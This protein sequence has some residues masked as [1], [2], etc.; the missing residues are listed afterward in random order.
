MA[1]QKIIFQLV[2]EDSGL[3]S[4][5]EQTRATIRSLNK[6]IRANPGPERF[7]ELTAELAASR[8][9]LADL[10]G[11]QKKLTKEFQ[12]LKVP[13]DSLAGLR[14]EY[15]KLSQAVAQLSAEERKSSFGKELIKNAAGVKKEIDGIEQSMGRFT[16]NVG[17][18]RSALNGLGSVFAALG[19]GAGIGEIINANTRVSDAIADVAKTAGIATNEAQQLADVL[20]FRDT[21][22]SLVDQLKIAQIGG[23]LGVAKEQ[24]LG[25]TESVDVLNV[26]LGDQFGN[27]E[28][29]TRVIAGLRNVLTDFKTGDVSN[30]VLRLGNALNFLEAQGNATAPTIA[31]F[32]NR[33][34]GSA[35]PLGVT[36]QEIFG[37][38]TA[39]AELNINPERGATAITR[40]LIEVAR[41]P[42]VFAKSLGFTKQQTED[43]AQ[44]VNTD[45]VGAVALVSKTIAEGGDGVKNFAQTLDEIGIDRAG[46]IEVLGKLGGNTA[47]LTQRIT[48]STDALQATD[49]VYAEFDKKNN[50]AAAAVE[51]LQNAVVNLIT[52]E[53]AQDAIES[54]AKA[55][56]NLVNV[57]GDTLAAV[58]D[59]K[60]EF[61]LLA[62]A[63]FAFTGPGQAAS[64][65]IVQITTALKASTVAGT[66]NVGVTN[67]QTAATRALA[68][69]QAALPLLA[70]VAGI[71]AVVKAFEFYNENLSA[72]EKAS[73]AVADA[74]KEIAES[75]AKEIVALRESIGVLQQSTST[76]EERA[77]AIKSLTDKYP[78]YLKGIDL[79][80]QGTEALTV[81][82]RELTDAI[83]RSAAERAKAS[84]KEKL[85][86][87][88]V[89]KRLKIEETRTRKIVSRVEGEF[90]IDQDR[91]G[92]AQTDISRRADEV[93]ALEDE[94]KDLE[95]QI[96]ALD[97][98]FDKVFKLDQPIESAIPRTIDGKAVEK[99]KASIKSA[100][101]ELTKEEKKAADKAKSEREK[102]ASEESKR[103]EEQQKRIL[104]IQRTVR[105]LNL[106]EESEFQRK[107]EELDNRRTDSLLQNRQRIDTLR[108]T[109]EERTGTKI[110]GDVSTGAELAAKIPNARP[111]DITEANLIDAE[112]DA[113]KASFDKQ[114]TELFAQRKATQEAQAAQLRQLLAD[115]AKVAADNEATAAVSVQQDIQES[116][117]QRRTFLE[118]EFS[119]REEANKVAFSRGEITR[120]EFE[121]RE[122]SDSIE[123]T[124]RKLQLETEYA[125]RVSE[126]VNQVRDV[127][128]AAAQAELDAQLLTIEQQRKQ[129]VAGAEKTAKDTGTDASAQISAI[130]EKAANDAEAAQ[131]R[132]ADAVKAS[133]DDAK[134]VQLQ[135]VD[136]VDAARQA[137]HDAELARI[138]SEKQKRAE[139]RDAA[140]QTAGEI[141]SG[142]LAIQRNND[143][144]DKEAKLSAI[145]EEYEKKKKAAQGNAQV[146]EK[147]EKEQAKKKEAVEKE[148]AEKRKQIAI[149]EAV[150]NTAQA[151]VKAAPNPLLMAFAAAVGAVQ[152]G[153]ISSQKFAEGGF[154]DEESAA[155]GPSSNRAGKKSK[156][157]IYPKKMY[158]A[159][160]DLSRGGYTGQG[161]AQRDDTGHR[162]AG[163]IPGSNAVVHAGEYVAPAWQVQAMPELFGDL[164]SQR[165]KKT[166]PFAQ[167]GFTHTKINFGNFAHVRQ[168]ATG[169]FADP[170]LA[171][172]NASEF[173]QQM[174]S[175]S[176]S[177]S[178]TDAQIQEIGRIIAAEN[179]RVVQRSIAEG[180]GDANRRLEREKSLEEQR[181]I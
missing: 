118:K 40:L 21:R 82:Y 4:R 172:P 144:A 148:A 25:F 108:K 30:D 99:S 130:N 43:F 16:G 121:Q 111:A 134:A 170:V 3:T 168:Y 135:A 143:E 136:A 153:V 72:A 62:S 52:S 35:I 139:I 127:R 79:E 71:Y 75:S 119:L 55:A 164:E 78:E 63:L 179:G 106:T 33:I 102:R 5:I 37:L 173:R 114:R 88:I 2:V 120:K 24:L 69:A 166:K 180:L 131:L 85:A 117:E 171:M 93:K 66:L 109:V 124:N 177:A 80:K 54:V 175:V 94:A 9:V 116:F 12:A 142:L 14:L 84:A 7:A 46:A 100:G 13:K 83:I 101:A 86:T 11:E 133:T 8:R 105:D 151:I 74:Q 27:V 68:A 70:V 20:E 47:L 161:T 129:G 22:T 31:E 115:T 163:K 145:D 149:I 92:A 155:P 122:L 67:L 160:P 18:Y 176:A 48:E 141:A 34:S 95:K 42:E 137:T 87:E 26:S 44:Q 77:K 17:N 158:D 104:E 169:G 138:E 110:T 157:G 89:E 60:A 15:G 156:T 154:T 1:T 159:L 51:K 165:R 38:S 178:F 96:E 23:Q 49:S 90:S 125:T 140:V 64:A 57:L 39:L 50:N 61:A 146:I 36:T 81:I 65:A 28:E 162:I 56:T 103:V 29:I 58:S 53:G 150:I 32:V 76:Q 107:V 113:L 10:V 123:Q 128:V 41:T 19:I 147:L 73:R 91:E 112:T 6:E 126:V 98:Q 181:T 45:L 152:V 167:G 59:N 132:F 97:K 174:V